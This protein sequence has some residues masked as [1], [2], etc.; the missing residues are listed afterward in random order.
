MRLGDLVIN[1]TDPRSLIF[2]VTGF[3][4]DKVIV[5][6]VGLPLTTV[7]PSDCLVKISSVP[8]TPPLQVLQGGEE[9]AL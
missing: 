2:Q 7:L 5:R 1:R 8:I 3:D 4:G 6:V 9:K